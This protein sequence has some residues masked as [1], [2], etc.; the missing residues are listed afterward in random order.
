M[1]EKKIVL[2]IKNLETEQNDLYQFTVFCEKRY[3]IFATWF[4]FSVNKKKKNYKAK[5][6]TNLILKKKPTKIILEEKKPMR[7]NVVAIDNV[8]WGKL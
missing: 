3:N 1:T 5:F 4:N 8:L 2:V 6:S 7:K